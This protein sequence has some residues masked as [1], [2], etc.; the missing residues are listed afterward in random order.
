MYP[1]LDFP[2]A[3]DHAVAAMPAKSSMRS[4]GKPLSKAHAIV[5]FRDCSGV[6]MSKTLCNS[7]QELQTLTAPFQA[8]VVL[9]LQAKAVR[10]SIAPQRLGLLTSSKRSAEAVAG[11]SRRLAAAVDRAVGRALPQLRFCFPMSRDQTSRFEA[12]W[13]ALM[14][15]CS[16]Q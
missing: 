15:Q 7:A 6:M 12:A 9:L 5:R 13:C 11:A 1:D 2:Q 16:E 3:Q 14:M 4:T 10:K 8:P